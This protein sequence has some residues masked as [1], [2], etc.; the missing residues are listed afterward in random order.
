MIVVGSP[1]RSNS[2]RLLEVAER[3]GCAAVRLLLRADDIDWG[4][5]GG[6]AQP[7]HY[8]R[9]FCAGGPGRGNHRR[10]CRMFY[11]SMESVLNPPMRTCVFPLPRESARAG[12]GIAHGGL[13]G[14][15]WTRTCSRSSQATRLANPFPTKGIAEGVENYQLPPRTR[16]KARYIL[17]L[18]EKRVNEADLPFFLGLTQS[19]CRPKGL[20]CPL[21]LPE[22]QRRHARS[23][24]RPPGLRSSRFSTASRF[25]DRRRS[26][27]RAL[28]APW[29]DLHLDGR[30]FADE[31]ARI[32]SSV[33][34]WQP[35]FALAEAQADRVSTGLAERS[36]F[37][38]GR[39]FTRDWPHGPARRRSSMRI[40]SPT[41]CSSSVRRFR[42]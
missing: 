1:I 12:S 19:P 26:I 11:R 17:T 9:R 10:F 37:R 16:R 32:R 13:Y 41:T 31:R 33:E 22:P 28:G 40:C 8:C 27:A 29:R 14:G 35:L 30:D 23:P 24:I 21:P 25:A 4:L 5:F 7:W 34:A 18:Y 3:A 39:R 36:P 20:N 2:Q 15:L 6:I 38:S 42:G